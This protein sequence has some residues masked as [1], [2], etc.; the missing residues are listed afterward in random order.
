MSINHY[1]NSKFDTLTSQTRNTIKIW[2]NR[3]TTDTYS[4]TERKINVR[5]PVP[6][7]VKIFIK[8]TSMMNWYE[9]YTLSSMG[10]TKLLLN[11]LSVRK[12]RS[13]IGSNSKAV[14]GIQLFQLFIPYITSKVSTFTG[15]LVN[16]VTKGFTWHSRVVTP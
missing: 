7:W 10:D 2:C 1:F 4:W 13:T 11:F 5:P 3:T 6:S 16:K 8:R 12:E 15:T 14:T 9:I